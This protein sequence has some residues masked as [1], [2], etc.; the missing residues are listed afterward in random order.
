MCHYLGNQWN[1]LDKLF[2]V[3]YDFFMCVKKNVKHK[4]LLCYYR[5]YLL[6]KFYIIVVR[7][8]KI[9]NFW[10]QQ[11]IFVKTFRNVVINVNNVLIIH[12][13]IS[14]LI[15]LNIFLFFYYSLVYLIVLFKNTYIY[16]KNT[17]F[18]KIRYIL[19][20]FWVVGVKSKLNW[21]V[22]LWN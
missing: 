7:T 20:L 1:R 14:V 21:V 19:D 8:V 3:F 4:S 9:Y 22:C 15:K 13:L 12:N 10:V 11:Q 6:T 2:W 17:L 16:L 18:Y 5:E